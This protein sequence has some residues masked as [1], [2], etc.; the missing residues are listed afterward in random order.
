M[1][2]TGR[3]QKC[4]QILN[5]GAKKLLKNSYKPTS[6]RFP[7]SYNVLGMNEIA[8]IRKYGINNLLLLLPSHFK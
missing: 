4:P 7:F 8:E 6:S 3:N 2:I 1:K 5:L